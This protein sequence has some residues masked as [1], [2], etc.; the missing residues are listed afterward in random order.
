M[1]AKRFRLSPVQ[2]VTLL[3]FAMSMYISSTVTRYPNASGAI[4]ASLAFLAVAFLGGAV[5]STMA[6]HED[7]LRELERRLRESE[8]SAER[9]GALE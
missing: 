1:L 2:T 3:V 7:R 8:E 9:R 6:K 4:P 5:Q